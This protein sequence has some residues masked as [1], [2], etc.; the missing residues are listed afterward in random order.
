M[1]RPTKDE[2]DKKRTLVQ[3][4]L[5]DNEKFL[6]NQNAADM[7]LTVTDY[8]KFKTLEINPKRKKATPQRE[9]LIKNLG[10]LGRIGA[11]INQIARALN[12][13]RVVGQDIDLP[14]IN[15]ALFALGELSDRILNELSNGD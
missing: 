15:L 1:A 3:I 10:E 14:Q 7:G 12:R 4:R 5:R 9:I 2:S 6:L 8:I 11:N 13:G